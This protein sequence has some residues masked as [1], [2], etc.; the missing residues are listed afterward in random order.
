MCIKTKGYEF[1]RVFRVKVGE[2]GKTY[3][4]LVTNKMNTTINGFYGICLENGIFSV[5][6]T[7]IKPLAIR[8][9]VDSILRNCLELEEMNKNLARGGKIRYAGAIG[10]KPSE[11]TDESIRKGEEK[12]KTR[13][14]MIEFLIRYSV[15][16]FRQKGPLQVLY[17]RV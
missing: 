15:L 17:A 11:M 5:S 16:K 10:G 12:R 13:D 4:I 2:E 14:H 9:I 8:G 1:H 3:R 6:K 7:N